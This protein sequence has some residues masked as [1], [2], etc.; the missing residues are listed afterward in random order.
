MVK[1]CTNIKQKQLVKILSLAIRGEKNLSNG[2]EEFLWKDIVTE[3]QAHGVKALIYSTIKNAGLLD[4]IDSPALN[5]W[6][7]ET[8]LTGVDQINHIKKTAYVLNKFNEASIPVIVLKGLVVRDL[9]PNPEFRTMGDADILVHEEDLDKTRDL[10]S[11]L[12]YTEKEDS[13]EHGAHI[14]FIKPGCKCVE[15]HWTLINDDYFRGTKEFEESLWDNA[16]EVN[17]GGVKTLSLGIEDL[18]LHLCTHMAVH[19]AC[20]GFGL[21]QLCDLVLLVEKEFENI[22]WASFMKKGRECGVEKFII[23]IFMCCN[24]LFEMKIPKEVVNDNIKMD[25]RFL[26]LLIQDIFNGGVF[27]KSDITV[28][29]GASIAYK[30]EDE[31]AV[32]EVNTKVIVRFIRFIFPPVEKMS[33]RYE[34]AKK[35]K[36]L[37]PIAWIH[38]LFA[39]IFNRQYKLKDK[40]RFFGY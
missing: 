39:G 5:Q 2:N 28:T 18:A 22:N 12:G 26:D 3:A 19:I 32:D 33:D 17:V 13:D 34:Y 4:T 24:K 38:H 37:T 16:M 7:K 10:F 40:V 36:L 1:A 15:V 25:S 30:K 23:A 35:N 14:V 9:Y 29:L 20:G 21:R 8:I 27:G 11:A 6:K 31:I